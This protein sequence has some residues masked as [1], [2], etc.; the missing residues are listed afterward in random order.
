M[1]NVRDVK[2]GNNPNKPS[3]A[4]YILQALNG[5][6]NDPADTDFQRGYEA[7]LKELTKVY[8]IKASK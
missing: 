6:D 7:C 5:F 4:N 3:L 8:H 1:T 2:F